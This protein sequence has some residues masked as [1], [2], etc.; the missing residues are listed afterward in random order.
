M[1]QE[2]E[3]TRET[4]TEPSGATTERETTRE[5]TDTGKVETDRGEGRES[6]RA[7]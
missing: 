4:E 7:S 5:T 6:G 3:T 1:S 2:R